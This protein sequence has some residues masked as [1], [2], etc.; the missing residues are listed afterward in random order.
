[1]IIYDYIG[2]ALTQEKI[3]PGNTATALTTGCYFYQEW[4]LPFDS[5]GTVT[6]VAGDWLVGATGGGRCCIVSVGT[7]TGTWGGTAAGTLR[8]KAM[9]GTA[10]VDNEVLNFKGTD[11]ATVNGLIG[12]V[13]SEYDFKGIQAKAVLISV[14]ANTALCAWDGSTPDQSSLVGQ[15]LTANSSIIIQD[16][17][18]IR[19]FKCIDYTASSASNIHVTYYF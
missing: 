12:T 11:N 16:I 10:F 1:M 18:A 15:P 19:K 7:I 3:I 14:Y 17:E 9:Q 6:N 5:G 4:D 13:A 2:R 8:V